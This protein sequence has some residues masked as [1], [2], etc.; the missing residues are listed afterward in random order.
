MRIIR[1]SFLRT[2]GR[3]LA[4]VF[5]SFILALIFANFD[6]D[7]KS[8]LIDDAYAAQVNDWYHGLNL[9]N[10]GIWRSNGNLI[11]SGTS[12]TF[13]GDNISVNS[14]EF[15]NISIISQSRLILA[16]ENVVRYHT[17]NY[18]VYYCTNASFSPTLVNSNK[19]YV[20]SSV[21]NMSAS[22]VAYHT[23]ETISSKIVYRT[24]TNYPYS[25]CYKQNYTFDNTINGNLIGISFTSG[26]PGDFVVLGYTL[27]D[28]GTS[29]SA[30]DNSVTN[31]ANSVIT[32]VT[33]R[34]NTLSSDIWDALGRKETTIVNNINS[35]TNSNIQAQAQAQI[36]NANSNQAQTN[37]NLNKI[38][39]S[40][41]NDDV[42]ND[43]A[44]SYFSNFDYNDLG[45]SDIITLPLNYINALSN[46]TCVPLTFTMPFVHNSVTL[47]CMYEIYETHFP[48]FL[49][50]WQIIST[51]II[52]YWVCINIF[53]SVKG[54]KDPQSDK[55][56]VMDL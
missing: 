21:S 48:N 40:I 16:T 45:L 44:T 12:T 31:N 53:A 55:V 1:N 26:N 15:R 13:N 24:G 23:S 37:S 50:V 20:G 47:P 19:V 11:S 43:Q 52:S 22:D 2:I 41:N 42:D 38:N 14:L 9:T 51:G 7:F 35:N 39:D 46:N 29:A 25:Y 36:S 5:I 30:I 17:Y 18:S 6:F 28:T 33:N 32:N 49:N 3:V 27:E 54:F 34:I 4:L 56:E 10:G 8:V